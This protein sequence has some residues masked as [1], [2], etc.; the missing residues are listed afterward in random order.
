MPPKKT[1]DS[2]TTE[3]TVTDAGV[4]VPNGT[5]TYPPPML[6]EVVAQPRMAMSLDD[7]L[8]LGDVLARSGFFK[9]VRQAAQAVVKVMFGRELDV[10]PMAA[11][12]GIFVIEG[13]VTIGANLLAALVK[14]HPRYDYRVLTATNEVAEIAFFEDGQEVGKAKFTKQE[15]KD[16]ELLSKSNWK[17]YTEDMLF[18]RA[19][20]RGVKRYCPDVAA[21]AP[22]YTP[23]EL[24]VEV[25]ESGLPAN[26]DAIAT[27]AIRPVDD[28]TFREFIDGWKKLGQKMGDLIPILGD[29][30]PMDDGRPARD[31]ARW[32]DA[33]SK[34]ILSSPGH[35]L[36]GLL[37]DGVTVAQEPSIDPAEPPTEATEPSD[38]SLTERLTGEPASP[39]VEAAIE[40]GAVPIEG[41][42]NDGDD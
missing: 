41:P 2:M 32:A 26:L 17:K 39:L 36:R 15:A 22:L 29:L 20:S 25:N 10:S 11:M 19:L 37:A 42:D 13:K 24:G 12:T 14:K 30:A 21:G 9:D 35:S 16:A 8:R 34:W 5:T 4:L 28:L 40:A 38:P 7:T 31:P 23:D 6:P 18:A 3:V 27:T 33:L 1:S